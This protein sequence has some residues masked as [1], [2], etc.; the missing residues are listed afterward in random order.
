MQERSYQH[1]RHPQLVL[2]SHQPSVCAE[3]S[4]ADRECKS[5][6]TN[7][8][9]RRRRVAAS[10]P[11]LR[12]HAAETAEQ[13]VPSIHKLWASTTAQASPTMPCILLVISYS[14]A[15]LILQRLPLSSHKMTRRYTESLALTIRV[16][17]QVL[18]C[19]YT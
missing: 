16:Q 5:V 15:C 9:T 18:T 12:K 14:L 1:S 8:H 10:T 11:A 19:V 6:A 2:H 13:S 7:M 17:E 3:H 4:E